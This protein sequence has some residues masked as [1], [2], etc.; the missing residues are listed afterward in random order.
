MWILKV[1]A[2]TNV[3]LKKVSKCGRNFT[4]LPGSLLTISKHCPILY[5]YAYFVH[6]YLTVY[7]GYC[8]K[9]IKSI[10]LCGYVV[11][12]INVVIFIICLFD[13][14]CCCLWNL[15]PQFTVKLNYRII[16]AVSIE[17]NIQIAIIMPVNQTTTEGVF[18][19]R[20]VFFSWLWFDLLIH[21]SKLYWSTSTLWH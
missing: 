4:W 8:C 3:F 17:N 6:F 11:Y 18:L 21:Y 14:L 1:C 12:N 16:I 9:I 10:N 7:I 2:G 19:F 13:L 5:L 15:Q 20:D